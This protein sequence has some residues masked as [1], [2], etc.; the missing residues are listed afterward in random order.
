MAET[1]AAT[2]APAQSVNGRAPVPG[3]GPTEEERADRYLGWLMLGAA[4]FL[5]FIAI[6]RLTA[7]ALTAPFT[8]ARDAEG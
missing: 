3:D 7:G 5:A 4:G 6:D 8:G 1:T 2:D